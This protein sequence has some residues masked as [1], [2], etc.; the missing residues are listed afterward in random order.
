M[1]LLILFTV[2]AT[3]L[4]PLSSSAAEAIQRGLTTTASF[5]G[6]GFFTVP[7]DTVELNTGGFSSSP[8]VLGV[9]S[10]TGLH[11]ISGGLTVRKPS[12]YGP[13]RGQ[14]L[15]NGVAIDSFYRLYDSPNDEDELSF[16]TQ[17]LL[18]P[19]DVVSLQL[20]P[21]G[22]TVQVSGGAWSRASLLEYPTVFGQ[23]TAEAIQRGLTTTAS[24]TGG[25]FFTVP[26]DTVE[27]N[28]GGFSSSPGVLGVASSTGLHTISGALTVRKPSAGPLRGQILVNGVAIDSFYRFYNSPNDEDELS[29]S[30]QTLLNPGDVVSLQLDP[31]GG[32][33]Q[34][35][36]G[37]WSRASLTYLPEVT[38]GELLSI[39]SIPAN[40]LVW[41]GG[42]SWT[43]EINDALGTA[44][45][46]P[47]WDWFNDTGTLT[48]TA[49]AG[50][51]FTLDVD[52]LT[53][54]NAPGNA[55]N[56]NP[57]SSYSW[58]FASAVGGIVGF[59]PAAFLLDLSGFTNPYTGTFSIAQ[60]GSNLNLLYTPPPAAVPEPAT[61]VI[62]LGLGLALGGL[63]HARRRRRVGE[64]ARFLPVGLTNPEPPG[65]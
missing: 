61:L 8:G 50:N 23:S 3:P 16:N 25:G 10:S 17:A 46:D 1:R 20:D 55:A 18:N 30:T 29:F 31:S 56:F 7:F 57:A 12:G 65:A 13:L 19:G 40:N 35:S 53:L 45:S 39:D 63:G 32:T 62:W 58:T 47:G 42:E 5:T 15:V 26:F 36:G 52:S 33:V 9:A 24:F 48:I 54:A 11:T 38:P 59:D 43:F 22:G 41:A 34:V 28:T 6:G 14:I 49:T 27:L 4:F 60:L 44:G 64:A 2:F 51:E 21:S 37:T